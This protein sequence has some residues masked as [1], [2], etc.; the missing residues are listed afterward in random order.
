MVGEDLASARVDI[1]HPRQRT[2]EEL[3]NRYI[4]P[5][6]AREE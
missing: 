3:P 4:Q 5:E 1:G 2:A 6:I